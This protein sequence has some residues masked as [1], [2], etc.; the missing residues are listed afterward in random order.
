MAEHGSDSAKFPQL[1]LKQAD[2][3]YM[4]RKKKKK[5]ERPRITWTKLPPHPT[6][7]VSSTIPPSESTSAVFKTFLLKDKEIVASKRGTM[8]KMCAILFWQV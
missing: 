2:C 7:G 6:S 4:P 5:A 3:T 8:N 1:P